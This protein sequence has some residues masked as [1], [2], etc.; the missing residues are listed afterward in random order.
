MR[1]IFFFIKVYFNLIIFLLL[2]AISIYLIV[3]YNRYHS[4]VTTAYLSEVTGKVN[5]Q[6][7]KVEY[8]LQL[9]KTNDSLVK[10]NEQLYNKLKADFDLPDTV[11]K[12]VIDTM[13]LDSLQPYRK[14]R[15]MN[16]K[17]IYNSVAME[18]NFIELGRGATGGIKK[19]MGVINT[20]NAV[21]GIVTDVSNNYA[22][23]MS[24]LNKDSHTSVKLKKSGEYGTVVWD[25]QEPNV[26]TLKEIRK[27]AKVV[28]G[29]TV[30]TS[31]LGLIF[32]YGL[33][34]GTVSEIV[35]DKSSNNLFIKIRSAANFYSL[36]YIYAI[37]NLKKEEINKLL[38]NAKKKAQ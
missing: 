15:Y 14:Y 11:S 32:P 27:S 12:I 23:V 31:G 24:L 25:G 37:E 38:E 18:N 35:P 5:T 4:A 10:A 17:V 16:A 6:Y 21:V 33:L 26:L 1:N 2:Q 22:I 30:V 20:N 9:K 34:V 13:K 3:H 29:D 36:Q 19:D 7:N 8:Y 28:K